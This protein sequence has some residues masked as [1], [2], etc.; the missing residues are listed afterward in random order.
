V[1][2]NRAAALALGF[3]PGAVHW[4]L[5]AWVRFV[6]DG[7]EI[8]MSK[9]AGEFISLDELLAEIG[10]DAARWYFGSRAPTTGID[11][12]IELAKRQSNENPVYY[13]QYAH[14]RCS[15]ILRNAVAAGVEARDAQASVQLQHPA[16][17]ALI[18]HLLLLPDVVADAA[19]R[20]ETHEVTRYCLETA[21]LFS[22][23]YRDCRVLSDD[24]ADAELSAA[25]LALTDATRQVLAN[26]LG[27]LGITAPESM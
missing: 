7:T 23:F 4:M 3:D 2:R 10:P 6:R 16:E 1:A 18:K 20:R 13:V 19:E 14:A 24:P 22:Q 17:Q 21:Q 5:M 27:L 26:A 11:F 12:D 8:G 9:R 15:S 25:R